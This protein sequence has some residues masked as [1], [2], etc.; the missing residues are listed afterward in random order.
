MSI[1]GRRPSAVT[2]AAGPFELESG[3]AARG[4][5]RLPDVGTAARAGRQRGARVPCAHRLGGCRLVGRAPRPRARPRSRRDFI[6]CSN[7]LGS[8]YGTT[9]PPPPGTAASALG[10]RLPAVTLRDVVRAA[11]LLDALGVRRLRLVIGG[12]MGG[13]QALEWA[14]LYPDRSTRSRRSPSGTPLGLVLGLSRRSGRRSSPTRVARR[15]AYPPPGPARARGR[16]ADGDVQLSQRAS[17]EAR[18][19]AT[20]RREATPSRAG[21]T[22]TARRSCTASMPART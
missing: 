22:G 20:R 8:C 16:P 9:G 1:R 11:A 10:R 19:A 12:S 17:L 5:G 6:V 21:C 3:A 14:L 2:S 15:T 13:M 18:F 4:D 7:V